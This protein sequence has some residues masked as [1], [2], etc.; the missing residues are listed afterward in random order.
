[1]IDYDKE[2]AGAAIEQLCAHIEKL[3]ADREFRPINELPEP[4][5]KVLL[6]YAGVDHYE[7]ATV[8]DDGDGR[9]AVLFDGD[10]LIYDPTHWMPLP[11]PPSDA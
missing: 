3:E 10:M 6:Y 8:Y 1:M 5:S 7:D 11:E 9:Y 2:D 4:G